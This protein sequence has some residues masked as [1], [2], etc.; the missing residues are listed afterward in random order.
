MN[1]LDTPFRTKPGHERSVQECQ[2]ICTE[3]L[4]IR[5]ISYEVAE[6]VFENLNLSVTRYMFPKPADRIEETQAFIAR[7]QAS[8]EVGAELVVSIHLLESG[9]FLGGAG[10]HCSDTPT[11]PELGIWLKTAAH[12]Q[13]FGREAVVGLM[14]WAEENLEVEHFIYPVDR[15]NTPSRKIP[16]TL[17]GE[18]IREQKKQNML[19]NEL[20][21]L[22]FAIPPLGE[23]ER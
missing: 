16:E 7:S 23:A 20:D 21:T 11:T 10:L 17:G 13:G 2:E 19:G 8:K 3:R 22:V 6:D 5:P 1:H 15:H 14:K 18:V 12:G 9:D 4:S